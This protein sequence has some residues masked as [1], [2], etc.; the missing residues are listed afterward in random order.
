MI[1]SPRPR[2]RVALAS[3]QDRQAIYT[4]RHEVYAKEL[5]QHA[6][7]PEGILTDELD[8][9]NHYIV[10]TVE[11][12][13]AG[14]VSVT[15]PASP[16]FSIDKYC[17]RE[18]LPFSLDH[19]VFEVRLLTVR[20]S[21]RGQKIAVLLMYAALRWI[22]AQGGKRVVAIGRREVLELYVRVGFTPLG[23]TVRS[24]AVS[25]ELMSASM[26]ALKEVCTRETDRLDRLRRTIDWQ[27][28]VPFEQRKPCYHGGAFWNAIGD[29]FDQLDRKERV[30]NADVL[31]AWFP[32][33]PEVMAALQQDL[34]WLVR[35][36][37]PM[38]SE[39]LLEAIASTRGVP[40]D[41]LVAGAGS[42]DLIFLAFRHWLRPSSRVL[43]IDPTY[44]EYLHVLENVVGCQVERFPLFRHEQ[45]RIEPTRLAGWFKKEYDLVVLVNPNS[46]TGKWLPRE[47]LEDLC[48]IA[49]AETRMWLDETYVDYLGE[50]VSL[51]R[52][53]AVSRNVIVCKSM[54]KVYALSGM[55]VGYL[56]APPHLAEELRFLSPPW[57][58]SLPAQVAAVAALRAS[59][60]YEDRYRQTHSLRT[61]LA[62]ALAAITGVDV[63]AGSA[64]FLLCHLPSNG[65]TAAVVCRA[66]QERGVFIRD[67]S[68]LSGIL[69]SHAVRIAVKDAH[70]NQR[71]VSVLEQVL[72]Q[73]SPRMQRS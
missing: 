34:H 71:I 15:P 61:Q 46:P 10:A 42:S 57:A 43:I 32:P 51:E 23:K 47:T 38:G 9:L 67:L 12:Q 31:D 30:I 39:G 63:I 50:D 16:S 4:I 3:E 35:T 7:R 73:A 24:G 8:G 56:C 26:E 20:P 6:E 41:C 49:P 68:S 14:F 11:G 29:T 48:R 45:Y 21:Y 25:F 37:P 33:A 2:I 53:A 70:T 60:Y 27:L 1:G 17:R 18:D 22:E 54:S 58:V 5:R 55:R 62:S 40:S 72:N 52:F 64:N 36:S 65:P 13:V 28:S 69:G 44:G 19:D 59:S 66:A